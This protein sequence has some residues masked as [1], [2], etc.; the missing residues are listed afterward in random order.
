MD[1]DLYVISMVLNPKLKDVLLTKA[2]SASIRDEIL[3]LMIREGEV[4]EVS[5]RNNSNAENESC[6]SIWD[7]VNQVVR[8]KTYR[9][10]YR[11]IGKRF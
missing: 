2:R 10:A 1:K 8:Q 6:S 7:A 3:K 9:N 5:P 11:N 4:C